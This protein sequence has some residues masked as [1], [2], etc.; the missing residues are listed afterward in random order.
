M[1]VNVWSKDNIPKIKS[2]C[3]TL[4]HHKIHRIE[5]LKKRESKDLHDAFSVNIWYKLWSTFFW[6]APLLMRSGAQPIKTFILILFIQLTGKA[7]SPARKTISKD[8]YIR[9]QNSLE[10]GLLFLSI[11]VGKSGLPETRESLKIRPLLLLE[12]PLQQKLY[13]SKPFSPKV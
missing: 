6:N 3:W 9:S 7:S 4:A 10:H 2:F 8:I 11:F 13:V 12:F 5:N 1:W